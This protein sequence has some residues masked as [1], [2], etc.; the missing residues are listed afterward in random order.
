MTMAQVSQPPHIR[1]G[2][3]HARRRHVILPVL[4][5]CVATLG[6]VISPMFNGRAHAEPLN[7]TQ[8][9]DPFIGTDDSTSPD[10]VPDGAGGST[11]PGAVYPYGMV[12]FSPDTPTAKPSGY[13]KS[14]KAIDQFS[15]THFDGAGCANNENLGIMPTTASLDGTNSPGRTGA[16]SR[17]RSTTRSHTPAT[18]ARSW[19]TPP[20]WNSAPPSAPAQRS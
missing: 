4:A 9:V 5:L 11:Y 2:G 13:R 18:T 10:P 3:R 8:Y 16:G 1:R 19:A 12:Q 14:D 15:M 17:R 7:L 6:L 20:R